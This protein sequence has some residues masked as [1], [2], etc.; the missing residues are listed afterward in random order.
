[1]YVFHIIVELKRSAGNF[2]IDISELNGEFREFVGRKEA[3]RLQHPDVRH[4][5]QDIKGREIA[6]HFTVVA[7]R[8]RFDFFQARLVFLPEFHDDLR[9]TAF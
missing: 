6:I 3:D 4:G 5:T 9:F 2:M 8:K 1:M 7:H